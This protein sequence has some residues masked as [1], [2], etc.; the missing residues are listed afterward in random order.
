MTTYVQ[1]RDAI[2]AHLNPAWLAGYPGV[3][4]FYEN[5]VQIDLDSVG[6]NFLAVSIDF[7][8]TIRMEINP[9]PTS[10]TYGIVTLRLFS[11][12]GQGTRT[13]LQ[14]FD[15]LTALMKY[16]DIGGVTLEC[17][18][19]G[20]KQARDGWASYDLSVPFFFYQ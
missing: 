1:A 19:P 20:P 12:E 15:W 4:L 17:P 2:V 18:T 3:R 9:N 16:R 7:D 6:N 11:K 8:D 10:K 14:M 13:T 5:A